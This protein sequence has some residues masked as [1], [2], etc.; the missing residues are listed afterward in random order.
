MERLLP[1]D[2]LKTRNGT[3][4]VGV[5]ALVLA[6]LLLL[7]YLSHYRSSVKS[8]NAATTVYVAKRLIPRGTSALE[9]AN[10]ALYTP[11]EI[12]SG[13]LKEGAVTDTGVLQGEVTVNAIYPGQQLTV[14]D[15]GTTATSNALSGVLTGSWRAISIPLDAVHGMIPQVQTDDHVD[16]YVQVNGVLGLMSSDVLVLQA[17]NQVAA[18]TAAPTSGNYI[19]RVPSSVAPKLAYAADNAKIWLALRG[20]T[21]VRPTHQALVT[22]SNLLGGK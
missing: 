6:T 18:G 17:P 2:M 4:A 20:Q 7:V 22:A 19:F 14:S 5:G 10:K 21:D 15:F 12:A 9:L 11:V 8:S 13:Q 16:V 3:I 1:R